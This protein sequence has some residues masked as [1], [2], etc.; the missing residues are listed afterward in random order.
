MRGK[1]FFKRFL[2]LG[3]P[4]LMTLLSLPL[5]HATTTAQKYKVLVMADI[6]MS[7]VRDTQ[8]ETFFT[9][10]LAN[11]KP[12]LV[13]FLGDM[14][15]FGGPPEFQD[16]LTTLD[17]ILLPL[18]ASKTYFT[19][20]MGNH[21][22]M[23]SGQV[24]EALEAYGENY[25]V[26]LTELFAARGGGFYLEPDSSYQSAYGVDKV[27]DLKDPVTGGI[28]TQLFLFD[29]GS[30]EG[31]ADS[32]DWVRQPQIDWFKSVAR[33]GVAKMVF[34]HISVREIMT[35]FPKVSADLG[36]LT[37]NVGGQKYLLIPN[38]AR[39]QGSIQGAPSPG[40]GSDGQF[41]ALVA[42]GSVA[43]LVTGHDHFNVF[44]QPLKGI[45]MISVPAGGW[46]RPT[47]FEAIRGASLFT[48]YPTTPGQYT[49][50][51][52]RYKDAAK[53]AGSKLTQTKKDGETREIYGPLVH[54]AQYIP[55]AVMSLFRWVLPDMAK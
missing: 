39:L 22:D 8:L 38:Y 20:V 6:H 54:Y 26:G 7:T 49:W 46:V 55:V 53:V 29:P 50:E 13:I 41:D 16:F 9:E 31:E 3:F 23:L 30:A 10:A 14:F 2:G 5:A 42:D 51:L 36:L 45:D 18:I 34:Q 32:Y 19:L 47:G 48:L 28:W 15:D 17:R 24:R 4:L 44:K 40:D 12:D 1:R 33:P 25:R 43:A 21:E 11:N 52:Y 37:K 35:A 27:Y